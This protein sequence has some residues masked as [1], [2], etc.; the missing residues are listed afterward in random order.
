MKE[1]I[2]CL[3][4]LIVVLPVHA[5]GKPGTGFVSP[6]R[7]FIENKGQWPSEVLYVT[8]ISGMDVWITKN[9][10]TY[11]FYILKELSAK[12]EVSG[13]PGAEKRWSC[14]GQVVRVT[15]HAANAAP[16]P[17]GREKQE[18]YYNYFIGNDSTKWAANVGLYK[19]AIVHNVYE[20][21]DQRWYFDNGRLRYDYIVR[22][23]ADPSH[24]QLQIEGA[25]SSVVK[26]RELVFSTRFGE[27]KQVELF[28][29][30]TI[31]GKQQ[32]VA[33]RWQRQGK[34][35]GLNLG[36]YNPAADLVIDPL[37]YSTFIGGNIGAEE[38]S[39]IVADNSGNAYITG[40]TG[41]LNFP[42][43]PGAFDESRAAGIDVFV[44]KLNPYGSALVYSTY[45]GGASQDYGN[46]IDLDDSGNV[47]ITGLAGGN[48]PVTPGALNFR[49]DNTNCFVTKLNPW[50]TALV[51]SA[52][53]GD[54]SGASIALDDAGNAYVTGSISRALGTFSLFPVTPGAFDGSYN[55]EVDAF[56]FKLNA[57]GSAVIYATYIGGSRIDYG[58]YVDVD[59]SGNAYV[60]GRTNSSTGNYSFPTTPG[61]FNESHKGIYDAFVCKFDSSGSNLVYSTFLGGSAEDRAH[62]IKVDA[63]GNAYVTGST[64][65]A[66]YPVVTGSFDESL[67]GSYDIFISKLNPS[68]SA[69]VYS[70]FIGGSD[71]ETP[72]EIAVD[73][74][75]SVYVT[76]ITRSANYPAT[77]GD[78][79]KGMGDVFVSK[80]NPPGSVLL[81]STIIGGSNI[82]IGRS[83]AIDGSGQVYITGLTEGNHFP[84]TPGAYDVLGRPYDDIDAFVAKLRACTSTSATE[85]ITACGSYTWIDG[86]TYTASNNSATY[87]IAGGNA[88][89]C[90]SIIRLRLTIN[91]STAATDVITTC[92]SYTWIDGITY[93]E[94]NNTATYTIPGGNAVGCDSIIML[95]LTVSVPD[96]S[97]NLSENTLTSAQAGASYQWVNCGDGNVP[98]P[99]QTGQSFTPIL[100][101]T[102]AVIVSLCEV[103]D[104]SGCIVVNCPPAVASFT[105]QQ[106][107][108]YH[109]Q[110][111]S[112]SLRGENFRW[113]FYISGD[114]IIRY[115][116]HPD[117]I[118]PFEG[119][120]RVTLTVNNSC[121][122]G[123]KISQDVEVLKRVGLDDIAGNTV[124]LFPNPTTGRVFIETG[125]DMPSAA[126]VYDILGKV[127]VNGHNRLHESYIDLNDRPA[128]VYIV[129]LLWRGSIRETVMKVLKQ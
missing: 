2:S 104:T 73:G 112:T 108:G 53:V 52:F 45:I 39:A 67:N 68:G 15:N 54:G 6:Q 102:Y 28:V 59:G 125:S 86:N 123:H 114:S 40:T 85:V 80:L 128:G 29:Y 7:F 47:Y 70:T 124:T 118:Y 23:G 11:R 56:L 101:G 77:P 37:V 126:I 46:D 16:M 55:G 19:E 13:L 38:G 48:Y 83:I 98:I 74:A 25:N 32:P 100:T 97:V 58:S 78:V 41:S 87:T 93:S 24:I 12:E 34:C 21:I 18:A 121:E 3:V 26:G 36:S 88:A 117:F 9:G 50:G 66:D 79:Y 10:V 1:L 95:N 81:Y 89:G 94:N 33:A 14:Y 105:Y 75:G 27:V 62:C 22:P 4:F 61:A 120:Y 72:A 116:E 60:A 109:V 8:R 20:G 113:V 64:N 69:L 63:W 71:S 42:V 96:P 110:F 119:T 30:Q 76:G 99:G 17:Q 106:Q 65:S 122:P 115:D 82:D 35:F 44:S 84:T 90:D 107:E 92:E 51:Y 91:R 43:T 103:D 111:T 129:K 49:Y 57:S 5:E 31:K 127:I